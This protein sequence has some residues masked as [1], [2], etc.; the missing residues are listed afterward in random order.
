MR[1]ITIAGTEMYPVVYLP[2]LYMIW[3]GF[4]LAL[5]KIAFRKI[6]DLAE[7]TVNKYDDILIGA[8]DLPAMLLI[9]ASGIFFLDRIL[10]IASD[11]RMGF[12]SP[13]FKIL[14][15]VAIVIF[16]YRLFD[17][18][19]DLYA[20]RDRTFSDSKGVIIIVARAIVLGLGM[21][22][23]LDTLGVSVTPILASLGIGSLAVA[24]ALQPTLEN[25]FSGIQLVA[26]KPVSV[27]HFIKLESGEEG[28][29][30]KIG[31]RSTWVRMLPNNMIIIPNKVLVNSRVLNYYYPHKELA[32]LVEVGV[33][34]DSDLDNVEKVTIDVAREVL[35]SVQG[36]VAGFDPFIRY[37]TFDDY[38]INFSVILRAKE[39]VDGYH[40]KH[41]FIKALKKRFN[42][43][44]I[45]IPYP[46]RT[47][48]WNKG[49]SPVKVS[50]EK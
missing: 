14:T 4:F 28:Y 20:G 9:F 7:K 15:I 37:H 18:F 34:Y 35:T 39:F 1:V 33:H 32:V 47:L 31:W 16:F 3:V 38:S 44:G 21:L 27:G 17:G 13:G 30:E 48:D 12:V 8:I 11:V 40:I 6:K 2:I 5:K 19:I 41:E 26:D 50:G 22:A 45:V 24:L 42:K 23:L 25:F 46:I 29:V 10:D 49:S 43:E 36:G